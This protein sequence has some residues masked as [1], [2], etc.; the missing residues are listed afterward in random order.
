MA[1]GFIAGRE[2]PTVRSWKKLK[3]KKRRL[4]SRLFKIDLL[5]KAVPFA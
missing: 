1:E 3:K 2:Y 4:L 5:G